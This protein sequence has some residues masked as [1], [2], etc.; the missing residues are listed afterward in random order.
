MKSA[1][2]PVRRGHRPLPA[3][4]DVFL[5]SEVVDLLRERGHEAPT[6]QGELAHDIIR[7]VRERVLREIGTY[8]R[9]NVR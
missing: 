6:D 9:E 7:I 3:D 2:Q 1:F 5:Q 8:A 4:Q